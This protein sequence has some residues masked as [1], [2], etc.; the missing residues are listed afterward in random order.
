[1]N[2][3]A[4]QSIEFIKNTMFLANEAYRS[5]VAPLFYGPEYS[6]WDALDLSLHTEWFLASFNQIEGRGKHKTAIRRTMLF[7]NFS[8]LEPLV[9]NA[10]N[11][12]LTLESIHLVTPGHLNRTKT[13]ALEQVRTIWEAKCPDDLDQA[14][15][16]FETMDGH[17]YAFPQVAVALDA[18]QL[19]QM[20]YQFT[21]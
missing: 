16:V 5:P 8:G 6:G 9:T 19:G 4:L 13:W 15:H 21:E 1:M 11:S 14:Y 12:N 7:S 3:K 10:P 17:R 18:V 2:T 20:S